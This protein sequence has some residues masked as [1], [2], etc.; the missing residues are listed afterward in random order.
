[1]MVANHDQLTEPVFW[2][3]DKPHNLIA[4]ILSE[5]ERKW[6]LDSISKEKERIR[7]QREENT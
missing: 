3:N 2:F 7:L 4:A 5:R 1:M 6:F